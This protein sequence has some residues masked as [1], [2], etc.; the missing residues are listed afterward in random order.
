MLKLIIKYVSLLSHKLIF[1][2][3]FILD[4]VGKR[5]YNKEY[6]VVISSPHRLVAL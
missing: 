2:P 5:K 4:K 6:F 1:I 3:F